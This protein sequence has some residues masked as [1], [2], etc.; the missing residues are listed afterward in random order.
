MLMKWVI[1]MTG[2]KNSNGLG[3]VRKKYVKGRVYYEGRYTDPFTHMQKSVSA[4][5]E[6]E[7]VRK[8]RDVQAKITTGQYVSPQKKNLSQWVDEWLEKKRNIEPGTYTNYES[9][10]RLYIKPRLGKARLQELRRAQCQ[11]FVNGLDK[12]PKYI[13]NI[14]GVLSAA[15]QD[16]VKMELI[17]K[18]PASDLDLPHIIR[19]A[20][21]AMES[22]LQT[23]FE[24]EFN[25]SPYKNIFLL[26]LH[27]GARISEVLGFLW[28]NIN[29]K[30]GEILISGQLERKRTKGSV[31]EVKDRTKTKQ[32]RSIYVPP[33]VLAFLRD[34]K[35]RQNENRLRA[36]NQ[37]QNDNGLVFT[38][39]DGSPMPHRTIENAFVRIR[40]RLGHPEVTLHT[41]RKTFITNEEKAGTDI[42]TIAAMA[43]HSTTGITLDVYT[44]STDEM[45]RQAAERRQQ[46]H[47]KQE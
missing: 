5:S 19:K 27:T 18:N 10:C 24:K 45:K 25:A 3:S 32:A 15:L 33:Y 35:R 31:R 23:A 11:E 44:A 38:R 1:R 28:K 42:K 2:K 8:L 12:S 36:G 17:P 6:S 30:S 41:L 22:D 43:G 21:V 34:E 14:V 4:T 40:N 47:E 16:A 37:W 26:A 39:E 7:C 9:I 13:H 20:P 29:L 46:R